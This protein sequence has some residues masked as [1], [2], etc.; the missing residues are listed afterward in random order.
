MELIK[1]DEIQTAIEIAENWDEIKN[2]ET[3]L[4]AIQ[5]IASQEKM[6]IPVKNKIVRYLIDIEAKKGEWLK[7][8]I[9]HGGSREPGSH[10]VAL[11]LSDLD[12]SRSESSRAQKLSEIPKIK[13]DE[14]LD[15]IEEEGREI[16]K[17]ELTKRIN[18]TEESPTII[19]NQSSENYY[20]VIHSKRLVELRENLKIKREQVAADLDVST[21][22]IW[23]VEN[24]PFHNPKIILMMKLTKY[25]GVDI[26]ELLDMSNIKIEPPPIA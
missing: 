14:I 10:N 6:A 11:R 24:I 2:T 20:N 22:A 17:T 26:R 16:T 25:F 12:I 19:K 21:S 4:K 9:Q 1:W 15:K 13:R 18:T 8:N 5:I 3:K 23:N 7:D